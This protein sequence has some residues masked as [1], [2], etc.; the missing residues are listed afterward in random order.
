[1][2]SIAA[3]LRIRLH[4]CDAMVMLLVAATAKLRREKMR[5]AGEVAST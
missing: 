5:L 2:T 4:G 3:V 1:V